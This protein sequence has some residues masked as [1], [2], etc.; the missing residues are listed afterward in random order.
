[1]SEADAGEA[2]AGEADAD[3]SPDT[4][5]Q[6]ADNREALQTVARSDLPAAPVAREL[7]DALDDAEAG[8]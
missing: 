3:L 7:L 6:L 8:E 5:Q 1:M 2:D 4:I